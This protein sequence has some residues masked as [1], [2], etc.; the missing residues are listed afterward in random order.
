MSEKRTV[1]GLLANEIAEC[2]IGN[3]V[4][5]QNYSSLIRLINVLI[6]VMKYY[7]MLQKMSPTTFDRNER[8]VA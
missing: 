2:G 4:E 1:H 7:S 5:I 3:L 8:K 6:C